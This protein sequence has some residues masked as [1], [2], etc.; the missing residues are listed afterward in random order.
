LRSPRQHD[1]AGTTN[2]FFRQA[3]VPAG[4]PASSSEPFTKLD[5]RPRSD[6]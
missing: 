6:P 5:M 4:H 1:I 3:S 2:A